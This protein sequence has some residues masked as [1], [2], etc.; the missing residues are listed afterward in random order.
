MKINKLTYV[1]PEDIE[2]S[3]VS[4]TPIPVEEQVSITTGTHLGRIKLFTTF[5][6]KDKK[7]TYAKIVVGTQI[8]LSSEQQVVVEFD[9]IW[10]A[11]YRQGSHLIQQLDKLGVIRNKQIHP[12]SLFNLPVKFEIALNDSIDTMYQEYITDIELVE[13]L[14]D[15]I[16]FNY[17]HINSIGMSEIVPTNESVQEHGQKSKH[18]SLSK[19]LAE[20]DVYDED[21]D[22]LTDADFEDDDDVPRTANFEDADTD[23]LG[24][25]EE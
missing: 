11:D 22:Y 9:R 14:P 8:Q 10:H 24:D 21:E 20:A 12:D 19:L 7:T 25:G 2:S 3:G 1:A 4:T 16:D 6:S 18:T 23:E 5:T 13:G 17:V 15:S